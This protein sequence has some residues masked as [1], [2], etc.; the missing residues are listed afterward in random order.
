MNIQLK[1]PEKDIIIRQYNKSD[2]KTVVKIIKESYEDP[3]NISPRSKKEIEAL[4]PEFVNFWIASIRGKVVGF[5]TAFD[6]KSK[7]SSPWFDKTKELASKYDWNSF[8]YIDTVAV[9]T[10]ARR[11]GVLSKL[12]NKLIEKSKENYYI[13]TFDTRA[14][15]PNKAIIQYAN[16]KKFKKIKTFT[17]PNKIKYH[18]YILPLKN[19]M[20]KS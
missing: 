19:K 17:A 1:M 20:L 13:I 14:T 3:L 9:I 2:I 5:L 10:N 6:N 4:L 12:I 16:K 15:P 7:Y 8:L 18:I 11:K